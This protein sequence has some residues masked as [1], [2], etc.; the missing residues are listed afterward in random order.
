SDSRAQTSRVIWD[1]N[2]QLYQGALGTAV[3]YHWG[4]AT[5]REWTG[6]L[7]KPVGYVTDRRYPLVIQTHGFPASTFHPSGYVPTAFAARAL[8]AGGMVVLQMPT[9]PIILS[10][11]EGPCNV[12]GFEAAVRSLASQGL[13]DQNRVGIIGFSRT[14]YYVLDALTTRA[15]RFAA[16]SVTDGV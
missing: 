9:C 13:I 12:A 10:P 5:G 6:G 8:A 16:A 1:P 4:D 2:P 3:V 11:E 14:V 7:Y 15:V